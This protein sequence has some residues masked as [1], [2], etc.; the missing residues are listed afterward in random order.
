M[1]HLLHLKK[2]T[3][4]TLVNCLPSIVVLQETKQSKLSLTSCFLCWVRPLRSLFKAKAP[5]S[6]SAELV[7][8]C[9]LDRNSFASN[10]SEKYSNFSAWC[11]QYMLAIVMTTKHKQHQHSRYGEGGSILRKHGFALSQIQGYCGQS[12]TSIGEYISKSIMR[13][14]LNRIDKE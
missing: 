1:L 3:N 9:I 4:C 5:P 8:W 6:K 13:N 10:F 2:A 14:S 7:S 11:M 12:L